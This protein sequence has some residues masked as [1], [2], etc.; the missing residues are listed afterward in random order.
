MQETVQLNL[1][2]VSWTLKLQRPVSSKQ[3]RDTKLKG[4]EISITD[5]Q[6]G[7]WPKLATFFIGYRRSVHSIGQM[8]N[9][10]NKAASEHRKARRAVLWSAWGRG[11]TRDQQMN[12]DLISISEPDRVGHSLPSESFHPLW[13][14]DVKPSLRS[15]PQSI[16][17]TN[18][19]ITTLPKYMCELWFKSNSEHFLTSM[20]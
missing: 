11:P 19:D 8:K 9:V 16:Q 10:V 15:S 4:H 7:H 6:H 1:S 20:V 5:Q 17:Q 3:V 14:N 18:T 13:V 2:T 12:F